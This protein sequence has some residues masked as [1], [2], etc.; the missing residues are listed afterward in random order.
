VIHAGKD[1]VTSPRYTQAIEAGIP[2]AQ[3]YM[4]DEVA[5]VVAGKEQKIKFCRLLFDF[6]D[7]VEAS[8]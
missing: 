1:I 7:G 6:L 3:G 4:W 5:H 2:G 8:E